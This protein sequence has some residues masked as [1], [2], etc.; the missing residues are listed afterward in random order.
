M[1]PAPLTF[2]DL[3]AERRYELTERAA[4]IDD[5]RTRAVVDADRLASVWYLGP[6]RESWQTWLRDEER[7]R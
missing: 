7:K 2:D 5:S 4:L 1:K 3:D 6:A